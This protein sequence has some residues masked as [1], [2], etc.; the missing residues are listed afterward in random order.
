MEQG[1]E[2]LPLDTARVKSYL[3]TIRILDLNDYVNYKV[4]EDDMVWEV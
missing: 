2:R 4:S 1:E 3:D